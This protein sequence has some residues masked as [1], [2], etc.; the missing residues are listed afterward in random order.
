MLLPL[1]KFFSLP[2]SIYLLGLVSL[3]ADVSS[4]M[5]Y[6]ITPTYLTTVLGASVISVGLI[7][8][9]A[10]FT[11]AVAKYL[12]GLHSDRWQTRKNP[13][14]GGY[15]LAALAKPLMG[16]AT[17]WNGVLTARAIDRLGKGLR[18]SPRD[19]WLGDLAP[20]GQRG[21]AFGWHRAMDNLG[22]FIGPLLALLM[23][24]LFQLDLRH[25]YFWALIPGL[26]AVLFVFLTPDQKPRPAKSDVLVPTSSLPLVRPGLEGQ[27]RFFLAVITVGALANANLSFFLLRLS[28]QG[29][30]LTQTVVI[31]CAYNL[32]TAVLSPYFGE[33]ADR[34]GR[35]PLL[36]FGYGM[37][38]I[39][40]GGFAAV[41]IPFGLVLFFLLGAVQT[42]S[43]EGIIK[44]F[45]L[46]FLNPEKKA[47]GLGLVSIVTGFASLLA[48]LWMGFCWDRWGAPT[49]F[50]IAGL[51]SFLACLSA[52]HFSQYEDDRR[53]RSSF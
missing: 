28:S 17:T 49:A 44:A 32:T 29:Q 43:T 52:I 47:T 30:N 50:A 20:P 13:V 42:A 53:Q 2:R 38:A 24:G 21:L 35:R 25:L 19:A 31:Y 23:L 8:G 40:H 7:E 10:E 3:F 12:S 46:D 15:L 33:R 27:W 37:A 45:A 6:P 14:A 16:L 48:G 22:A 41:T 5:L 34:W 1:R 4:E 26:M 9:L 51:G 39:V 18:T 11:A 36:I